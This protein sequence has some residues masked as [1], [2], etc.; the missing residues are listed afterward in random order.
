[1]NMAVLRRSDNT[2][3]LADQ[4]TTPIVEPALTLTK[5]VAADNTATYARTATYQMRVH[6]TGA[7]TTDAFDVAISDNL[8]AQ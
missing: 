1:M 5:T 6:H 7:H 4:I 8:A 3:G 2:T